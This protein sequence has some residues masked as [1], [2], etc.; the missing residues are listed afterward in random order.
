MRYIYFNP[1]GITKKKPENAK[2]RCFHAFYMLN[3]PCDFIIFPDYCNFVVP[4]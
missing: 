2:I 1:C 4:K 3:I